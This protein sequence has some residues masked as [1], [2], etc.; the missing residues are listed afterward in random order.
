MALGSF[1]SIAIGLFVAGQAAGRVPPPAAQ[2][3]SVNPH[4][5]VIEKFQG[6]LKRYQDTRQ[7][8]LSEFK[9]LKPDADQ[10][11]IAEREKAMGNALRTARVGAKP[12]EIFTADVAPYF[13]SAIKADF[14]RRSAH[15]KEV[16][17]DELP[18]FKPVINQ[19]YPSEWPLQTFP[20]TLLKELPPLPDELEYRFVDNSLIL[21]DKQ[22]NIVVDFLQN[23]M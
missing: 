15:G 19:T 23:V 22:A 11:T 5:A 1:V 9:P 21:R 14:Q 20:P 4:A 10:A 17:L 13:R 12:G 18:H 16:R 2:G 8:A 6:Q 7:R 3:R